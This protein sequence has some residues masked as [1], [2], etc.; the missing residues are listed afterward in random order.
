MWQHPQSPNIFPKLITK[1]PPGCQGEMDCLPP[2][3]LA[4]PWLIDLRR[5]H[6]EWH[7]GLMHFFIAWINGSFMSILSWHYVTY[8]VICNK[9]AKLKTF[10]QKS[11]L[12]QS[13]RQQLPNLALAT[14]AN[15]AEKHMLHE[16]R[17][18]SETGCHWTQKIGHFCIKSSR[19]GNHFEPFPCG[20]TCP[21]GYNLSSH[22][23]IQ[24]FKQKSL[25]SLAVSRWCRLRVP[26]RRFWH[27]STLVAQE[28]RKTSF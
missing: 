22:Q 28:K 4:N 6:G 9:T 21:V 10:L 1:S 20:I 8:Y 23:L 14:E 17:Y 25:A 11:L 7:T 26:R 27:T 16:Y 5:E 18:G 13:V 12:P 19:W 24:H 3:T 2:E 15:I